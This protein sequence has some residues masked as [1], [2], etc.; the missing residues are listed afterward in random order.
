MRNYEKG[1]IGEIRYNERRRRK[2]AENEEYRNLCIERSRKWRESLTEE[3]KEERRAKMRE[4]YYKM[5]NRY[6]ERS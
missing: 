2:Y 6:A 4:Y 3:Q 5:K 1:S